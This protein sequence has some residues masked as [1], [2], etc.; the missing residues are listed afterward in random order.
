M[1]PNKNKQGQDMQES[2]MLFPLAG[3]WQLWE[4]EL[5]N[6]RSEAALNYVGFVQW[7]GK[8]TENFSAENA[9]IKA[10]AQV[11]GYES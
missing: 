7:Q 8:I 2:Q 11:L 3:R 10:I 5:G 9:T 1:L 4:T 6:L